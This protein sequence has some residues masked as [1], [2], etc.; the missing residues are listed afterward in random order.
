MFTRR[1]DG[2]EKGLKQDLNGPL[3]EMINVKIQALNSSM[4]K[5]R[6][7]W[8]VNK[9]Q[10]TKKAHSVIQIFMQDHFYASVIHK[11]RRSNF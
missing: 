7:I 2:S 8:P 4:L 10:V 3:L 1:V 6:L 5:C 9:L 11:W